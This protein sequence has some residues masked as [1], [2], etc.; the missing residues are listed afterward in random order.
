[1]NRTKPTK[2]AINLASE[3]GTHK[4]KWVAF[5]N[6]ESK[7]L[8]SGKSLEKVVQEANKM[9]EDNPVLKKVLSPDVGYVV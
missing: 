5:S 9:G 3:L 1:M 8:S 7:I 2:K 4:N 6:D